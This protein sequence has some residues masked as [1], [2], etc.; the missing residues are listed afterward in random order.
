[1]PN[2]LQLRR[3]IYPAGAL[4]GFSDAALRPTL[5]VDANS[6]NDANTGRSAA[7]A[8][9]TLAAAE[10]AAANGEIIGLA[11]GSF[12]RESLDVS[13]LSGITIMAYGTGDAPWITGMDYVPEASWTNV[14]GSTP[15]VYSTSISHDADGANRLRVYKIVA[16][17]P[18]ALPQLSQLTAVADLATCNSTPDSFVRVV[19]SA[20]SPVTVYM[21]PGSGFGSIQYQVTTRSNGIVCGSDSTIIG[22]IEAGQCISNNGSI[23][24]SD[25]SGITVKQCLLTNGS[26]HNGVF[27]ATAA[28]GGILDCIAIQCDEPTAAE[29][30]NTAFTIFKDTGAG[31][32]GTFKRC[33][34]I[35]PMTANTFYAHGNA[36]PLDTVRGEQLWSV[37]GNQFAAILSELIGCY[38]AGGCLNLPVSFGDVLKC[39]FRMTTNGVTGVGSLGNTLIEDTCLIA[40]QRSSYDEVFRPGNYEA[41]FEHCSFYCDTSLSTGNVTIWNANGGSGMQLRYTNSVWF[42]GTIFVVNN[43]GGSYVGDNNVFLAG[44]PG[45]TVPVK[46]LHSSGWKTT[47]ASWQSATGQ[48]GNSVY[49]ARADQVRGD[50]NAFWLCVANDESDGPHVDGDFRINPTARVYDGAN[51][52]HIGYLADDTTPITSVGAQFHWDWNL[53]QAV[54]GPAERFPTVPSTLAEARAYI[55]DPESWDFYP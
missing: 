20:G 55:A 1:M 43:A 24:S 12:W 41:F 33:G 51:A 50:S 10:A 9:Q 8:L 5:F 32:S 48:D 47:L 49:L 26:K 34:V 21:H 53:R 28:S 14:G 42:N 19:G 27:G 30:S 13:A 2:L 36:S 22:P 23:D 4:L 37:G 46:F 6:G 7:Q 16:A 18:P 25:K 15:N 31:F 39:L 40:N 38:E 35:G 3:I 44:E 11:R 52:P 29:P 17:F 54:A 45:D